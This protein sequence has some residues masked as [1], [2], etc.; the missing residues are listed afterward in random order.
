MAA[1][2][3]SAQGH[4]R[5]LV[6][7]SVSFGKGGGVASGSSSVYDNEGHARGH[8]ASDAAKG[9]A[10]VESQ[11]GSRTAVPQQQSVKW[12]GGMV[13]HNVKGSALHAVPAALQLADR[14]AAMN[15]ALKAISAD[16]S[17]G[18]L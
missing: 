17:Q 1:L 12:A 9:D 7:Q 4:S 8:R 16:S 15:D 2:A 13:E 11:G 10:A 18:Y 5:P 3:A 6:S 14:L